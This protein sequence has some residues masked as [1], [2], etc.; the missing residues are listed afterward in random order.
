MGAFAGFGD[1]AVEFYD[2]LIADNSKAYWTDNREV[3][4]R[5]VRGPM[6]SLLADLEP[7]FGAGKVFRPHRDVRFSHDKTPYK[8]HCGGYAAPYYVEVGPNG[9]MAAGGYYMM[10]PDQVTRFRTAVDDERRG[11]D[12]RSRLS[13]AEDAGLTV[14]GEKLKTRPKGTDPE[15]PRLDL[16]RHKGI[17]VSR[18]WP[19]DDVLHGP[20]ARDRVRKVWRAATP[21]AEWLDDHVG[22]SEQPRR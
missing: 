18:R 7:E 6:E 1:A 13:A 5:D 8:T 19:P 9:L 17:H 10:A 22:P 3:Y 20:K 2:G 15:H 21:L 16:L 14:G 12:L 4:E 11:E